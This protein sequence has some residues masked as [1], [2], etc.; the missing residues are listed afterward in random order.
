MHIQQDAQA[1][2]TKTALKSEVAS[3]IHA[4]SFEEAKRILADIV[5]KY[6]ETQSKL[7]AWMK[8]NIPE[9][10]TIFTFPPAVRQF[11]RTNNMEENLYMQIK[12]LT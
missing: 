3:D 6:S 10:L 2:I 8:D 1:H 9:G 12:S 4:R 7:A 5:E 11:L